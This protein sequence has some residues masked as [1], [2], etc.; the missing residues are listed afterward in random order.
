MKRE[1]PYGEVPII[2][3]DLETVANPENNLQTT[4][5]V[6]SLHSNKGKCSIPITQWVKR[7]LEL[8]EALLKVLNTSV[9]YGRKVYVL[10]HN[11][12][13]FDFKVL[14]PTLISIVKAEK[15]VLVNIIRDKVGSIYQ[16]EIKLVGYKTSF[17]LRDSL[18]LITT[19]VENLNKTF[20]GGAIPKLS[21][22]HTALTIRIL[23]EDNLNGMNNELTALIADIKEGQTAR[24]YIEEYVIRDCNIVFESLLKFRESLNKLNNN[25]G[26]ASII[27]ISSL[28][29]SIFQSSFYDEKEY[30]II[31]IKSNSSLHSDLKEAYV[32][33]RVEVFHRGLGFK[34]NTYHFDVPGIYALCIQKDLPIGN[35]VYL[36]VP[37]AINRES[38]SILIRELH[39]NGIIAFF[40]ATAICPKDLH[41]PV[42]PLKDGGKLVFPTGTIKGSWTSWELELALSKGYSIFLESGIVF[43]T[44]KPLAKYTETF[45][46]VK[47]ECGAKGDKVGRTVAKLIM[48]S[49][50]GKFGANY[51]EN[52][53]IIL[54][55]EDIWQYEALY[56]LQDIV[57]LGRGIS[58]ICYTK[59]VKYDGVGE[60]N[61]VQKD[62]AK[63]TT[64]FLNSIHRTNVGLAAAVTSH[65]RIILYKLFEEVIARGGI[66]LYTD[67][68]SIFAQIPS[69]PFNIPFGPF[70]WVEEPENNRYSKVL[71]IAPKIY[72]LEAISG[73]TVFKVKG[74]N[75][76]EHDFK[77]YQL[78]NAFLAHEAISFKGQ[79]EFRRVKTSG[80][81]TGIEVL[82]NLIKTY[83][84]FTL[85][86]RV[87]VLEEDNI[88]V[89][90]KP[91]EVKMG[92]KQLHLN[93]IKSTVFSIKELQNILIERYSLR[94]ELINNIT[95]KTDKKVLSIN[96]PTNIVGNTETVQKI[97]VDLINAVVQ[98]TSLLENRGN[99]IRLKINIAGPNE[100][101]VHIFKTLS[102]LRGDSWI[103][104][105]PSELSNSLTAHIV[106]IIGEYV[107]TW[108][109]NR[110]EFE[111]WFNDIPIIPFKSNIRQVLSTTIYKARG[112]VSRHEAIVSQIIELEKALTNLKGGAICGKDLLN[113]LDE[114]LEGLSKEFQD[115]LS[116]HIRINSNKS[117]IAGLIEQKLVLILKAVN[118]CFMEYRDVTIHAILTSLA[119]TLNI[120]RRETDK[121]AILIQFAWYIITAIVE[122][123]MGGWLSYKA[124]KDEKDASGKTFR[125][126]SAFQLRGKWVALY[127]VWIIQNVLN[128]LSFT[129]T[130]E[131]EK[132]LNT[133]LDIAIAINKLNNTKV[134]INKAWA[135]YLIKLWGRLISIENP[136]KALLHSPELIA[137][138]GWTNVDE[139]ISN[140]HIIKLNHT[141]LVI[142]IKAIEILGQEYFYINYI[143]D[144][145]GRIYPKLTNFSHIGVKHIRP[146]FSLDRTITYIHNIKSD[147]I[148]YIESGIVG[149]GWLYRIKHLLGNN[150]IGITSLSIRL[151][152]LL[153]SKKEIDWEIIARKV[154]LDTIK[155]YPKQGF[156]ISTIQLDHINNVIQHIGAITGNEV[157]IRATKVIEPIQGEEYIDFYTLVGEV[158][159]QYLNNE[160]TLE[161]KKE[162]D[163]NVLKTLAETFKSASEL[164]PIIKKAVITKAY[165]VTSY[166]IIKYINE[167][168]LKAGIKL[169]YNHAAALT[170]IVNAVLNILLPIEIQLI[171]DLQNRVSYIGAKVIWDLKPLSDFKPHFENY[172]DTLTWV[173]LTANDR[174]YKTRFK[175]SSRDPNIIKNKASVTANVIHSLDALQIRIVINRLEIPIIT[176]HDAYLISPYNRTTTLQ[177][178][179]RQTFLE[180]HGGF[181]V[182]ILNRSFKLNLN[183]LNPLKQVFELLA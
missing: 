87:W 58:I 182:N 52:A 119:K 147:L 5:L 18:K 57:S 113:L 103:T 181:R 28:S 54:N 102:I 151:Q 9:K 154:E 3:L 118:Y 159:I 69:N 72:Y 14:L 60:W 37:K 16:I 8:E 125:K 176:L 24:D 76:K 64:K 35:P 90:T 110:I 145:R 50:Y 105:K 130:L 172:I 41:I 49:L 137:Q 161:I 74:V 22:N 178:L 94:E 13:G 123:G 71:F 89:S 143:F 80:T 47:D 59:S 81:F 84:L 132:S 53:T 171:K 160:I 20:L 88:T 106:S 141:T 120:D 158:I 114:K 86:K 43:K 63:A 93:M 68:D 127:Q 173:N 139:I 131:T 79:I 122:L 73:K 61:A 150:I 92:T 78:E 6:G 115:S 135:G 149:N 31:D 95:L 144:T 26:A 162:I 166:S 167:R 138:I 168:I 17:I 33:G 101:G 32:G 152:N 56:D 156:N 10:A 183:A 98:N 164:R 111:L 25:L 1:L 66:I 77:Y 46:R 15:L 38:A 55:D 48:N 23:T 2:I 65:A 112:N 30:P 83:N 82:N 62:M 163:Q 128:K 19:R 177:N 116:N 107:G 7:G 142:L 36:R 85:S 96:I 97:W 91:I 99:L 108:V 180:I 45:T 129:P 44:G 157:S 100:A 136:D 29:I 34:D 104:A 27:T 140:L 39:R 109:P 124:E 70:I 179:V 75:T 175:S 133:R 4:Y 169:T 51:H 67:T 165:A 170:S 153:D 148:D 121:L 11:G 40:K 155:E 21:I 42:L 146:L 117:I 134:Y 12:G 174:N 126:I